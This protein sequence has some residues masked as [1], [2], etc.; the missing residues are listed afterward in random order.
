[1]V[2]HGDRVD[3]RHLPG[4]GPVRGAGAAVPLLPA[5]PRRH[6][7]RGAGSLDAG[8]HVRSSR[9]LPDLPRRHHRLV[10]P[11]PGPRS[12]CAGRL[13]AL[14]LPRDG[15]S[16]PV[17]RV[18]RD[19]SGGRRP[20][21]RPGRDP[22][23]D[24]VRHSRRP[25]RNYRPVARDR[26]PPGG[27]LLRQ[28][29]PPELERSPAESDRLHP[30]RIRQRLERLVRGSPGGAGA[31]S[32]GVA[33]LGLHR[34]RLRVAAVDGRHTSPPRLRPLRQ[35]LPATG[36][37]RDVLHVDP[38]GGHRYRCFRR[39]VGDRRP[40]DSRS[41]PDDAGR[42]RPAVADA[43]NDPN[44]RSDGHPTGWRGCAAEDERGEVMSSRSERSICI[45]RQQT[46]YEL[47]VRREAEAFRDAGFD[48]HVIL[49]AGEERVGRA[50]VDGVT[51]HRLPGNR[52]RGGTLRYLWDYAS[53]FIMV[54]G[55]LLWLKVRRGLSVVQVNTMP[56]SLVFATIWVRLLG[57]KVTV[58]M[59]EPVPELFRTIYGKNLDRVLIPLEQAAIRYAQTAF[60]VTDELKDAYV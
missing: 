25:A 27:L 1:P 59:K 57:T 47:P 38:G 42:G 15:G 4:V 6:R 35:G 7:R 60:T 36:E 53:F 51:L 14:V 39:A 31:R 46:Y 9:H 2:H 30:S 40:D 10:P 3:P 5:V 13:G 19:R 20:R 18:H 34:E 22:N 37:S 50:S 24:E 44:W 48:V 56:D 54:M 45:V 55:Y 21:I 12:G 32:G 17:L 33:G 41:P 58:F 43:G 29:P 49:Q 11:N 28:R 52:V 26:P 23:G 16:R 8:P